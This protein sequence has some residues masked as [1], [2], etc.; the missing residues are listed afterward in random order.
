MRAWLLVAVA[1]LLPTLAGCMCHRHMMYGAPPGAYEHHWRASMMGEDGRMMHMCDEPDCLMGA[2]EWRLGEL[3][4]RVA[5]LEMR[6]TAIESG[7]PMPPPAE[8]KPMMEMGGEK[9]P[10]MGMGMEEKPMTAPPAPMPMPAPSPGE[11]K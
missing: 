9:R 6:V 11:T 1:V 2:H 3:K 4:R 7:K 5:D 8:R 10:M